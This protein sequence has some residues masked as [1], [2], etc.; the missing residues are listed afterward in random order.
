MKKIMAVVIAHILVICSIVTV[1]GILGQTQEQEGFEKFTG[2][3]ERNVTLRILENDTAVQQGYLKQLLEA[4]NAEYAEYGIVAVDAN[5]DEYS[6]L[7]KDGP[8]GFGPDVIYQA[9]DMLMRYVEG[10]HIQPLPVQ[11]LNCY[12][13]IS[14]KAWQPF[15]REYLD[16]TMTF[17]VPVNVQA[18]LLYYRKDLIPS[19]WK[20]NWDKDNNDVPDM[21]EY[22][23]DMYA[24]SLQRRTGNDTFGYMKSLFDP[25]FA[26]GY[27]YSY[28][29]YSFGDNNT[30]P[31]DVG[32]S[33]GNAELG[34]QIMLQQAS[35]MNESCID[36]SI[37]RNAYSKIGDG[38]YFATI[39]T[40]DVYTLFI[41]QLVLNGMT[42]QEAIDNLGV[43]SVPMLPASGDLTQD[44]PE[45]IANKVMGGVNGYAISSYTKYPNACL[46][47]VDFATSYEMVKV[48]NQLLG[49]SPARQD[50]ADDVGGLSLVVSS[51]LA[52]GNI[53]IMPSITAN[54]EMW[55]PLRTLFTDVA[56]DAFRKPSEKKY[57]SLADIKN[58][59]IKL[60]NQILE[61]ITVLG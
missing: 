30:N 3:L 26:V 59:L 13:H 21:I 49:I 9:N 17:G 39:T 15:E 52:Q 31:L 27:L 28:G 22:W 48:R 40:P 1:C 20:T 36:D 46:A 51:N 12:P 41:D 44:N 57:V 55:T 47:F 54:R 5:M 29:G 7:E 53:V 18:P 11:E 6:D 35:I 10:K 43:A 32:Y 38:S 33:K 24:F 25:Y 19:D 45:Y 42:R 4:F 8:F 58:A 61:A 37:T 34:I 60:D 23:N 56:T 50:A 14:D 2:Q 16:E